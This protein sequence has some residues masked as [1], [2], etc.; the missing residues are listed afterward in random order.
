[1]LALTCERAGLADGQRILELGCGWGSLSLWMAERLPGAR[2]TAVSNSAPQG[3]FIRAR[4]RARGL[5]QPR[6]ADRRRQPLRPG[7]PLRPGG[8]G[9]DVRAPAQLARGAAPG[10]AAGS[11]RTAGSSCTSSRTGA[12]PTGS[13]RT[14]TATGWPATSSPAASCR[15]DDLAAR[16]GGP[17]EVEA[18]LA[19]PR[20][21]LRPHRRGVAASGSTRR[22]RGRWR[23]SP[24]VAPAPR[25]SGRPTAGAS[26]SSPAPSSSASPAARSGWSPTPGCGRPGGRHEDRRRRLGRL[27]PGLR[28]P[29]LAAPRRGPPRG[30]R[31]GR[32]PRPH[33][34]RRRRRAGRWRSTPASSSSTRGP[35]RP[36]C[37]CSSGSAWAGRSRR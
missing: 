11:S 14:A 10:G 36:S 3:E 19:G 13:R 28:P 4:A 25:P 30:R 20:H 16:V 34:G 9:G 31:P 17:L 37:G 12:S 18:Q 2:I 21:P 33:G 27:R 7:R 26:S 6:G 8:V 35:T 32:R 22:G 1:M 29:A 24:P 5:G 15:S 23:R